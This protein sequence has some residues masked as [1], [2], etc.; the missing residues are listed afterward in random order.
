MTLS[1]EELVELNRD[2]LE[3]LERE[4]PIVH[5]T[6]LRWFR[7]QDYWNKNIDT[8]K[9]EAD[10]SF[11]VIIER[12]RE[13]YDNINIGKHNNI[14]E[15]IVDRIDFSNIIFPKRTNFHHTI[16]Y[17]EVDFHNATFSGNADFS[18]ATFSNE[19]IFLGAT[20]SDKSGKIDFRATIFYDNAAFTGAIF[21]GDADFYGVT[22]SG[23]TDFQ[24]V[25]FNGDVKFEKAVFNKKVFFNGSDFLEIANFKNSHFKRESYFIEVSFYKNI[26]F[27][28]CIFDG[29]SN[30][31][32]SNFN[33][34]NG[35][36]N[37]SNILFNSTS[38]YRRAKFLNSVD[39]ELSE[40]KGRATFSE[41]EFYKEA[42]FS[43]CIF[44][45][46]VALNG[47]Y[48]HSNIPN[49][50]EV[51]FHAA[52]ML[53]EVQIEDP[54]RKRG[55]SLSFR[56]LPNVTPQKALDVSRRFRALGKM[57]HEA[58]DW[59]NEME[60]FAQE[61]RTRRFG[62]DFP[63]GEWRSL[64]KGLAWMVRQWRLQPLRTA[65]LWLARRINASP[66]C[67]PRVGLFWFGWIYETLSRFGRSFVRPCAGW[68]VSMFA[69]A[70]FYWLWAQ[71]TASFGDL[72]AVSFR[73]GLVIS[74]LVRSGYY[75]HLLTEVFGSVKN[76]HDIPDLPHCLFFWMN[77]QTV[78]S[79]FFLFLFFLA[80][81]NHFR[82]R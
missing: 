22:F 39:F 54:L 16:F 8:D 20:F 59:L 66:H 1:Y 58:R 60:F 46:G 11:I 13:R 77:V 43:V 27:S 40:F 73:Q 53:D 15:I 7:G 50:V 6:L 44:N 14:K 35:I 2:A 81:R 26:S 48:F 38:T 23:I 4:R 41:A 18:R 42:R 75:Q 28:K 45:K 24:D 52:P 49:L 37:F 78:L 67:G 5:R 69:F 63:L 19:V 3:W 65:T 71:K 9:Y 62:M 61:I 21:S 57:A 72:L 51:D 56:S 79:A 76:N 47:T 80:V 82:I 10:F 31:T 30:F 36:A 70:M 12:Y 25:T 29:I 55:G 74:G 68:V 17:G 32:Y 33:I 64:R 34:L